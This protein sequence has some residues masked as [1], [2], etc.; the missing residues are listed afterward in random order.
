MDVLTLDLIR[1]ASAPGGD[2]ASRRGR[3]WRERLAAIIAR[4]ER[5]VAGGS[6]GSAVT[7]RRNE[8]LLYTAATIVLGVGLLAVTSLTS[9]PWPTIDP[10]IGS[11]TALAGPTG[12]LLLWLLYGLIGSLRVLRLPGGAAMTFHLPFVGAAMIVGGPTAGAWV[13]FLSTIE[14]RELETQP[15]YG[16]LANHSILVIAAV[17]G[18]IVT[19]L[20]AVAMGP[21]TDGAAL[22]V[23]PVAGA[24]VLAGTSTVLGAV[25]VLLREDLSARALADILLGQVGRITAFECALVVVLAIAYLEVGWWAPLVVAG[26]VLVV[27]DNDPLPPP[28]VVTGLAARETFMRQLDAGVGRLRRRLIP[29]ATILYIDLDWFKL[30]NDN[31]GPETGDETLAEVG[32]RLRAQARRSGDVAGRLGG[33]EFVLFLPGLG[34]HETAVRRADEVVA[35]LC[36]PIGTSSGAM[37]IG[38]S[39]GVVVVDAWGGVPSGATLVAHAASAMHAA[40]AAG[41]GSHLFDP[42]EPEVKLGNRRG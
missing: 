19:K 38:A 32:R 27:W 41:G 23:P 5:M 25:T 11:D 36:L 14:R 40:K 26:F 31:Y 28:D 39:I 3:W 30:I 8:L 29:S 33:D 13:A 20:V 9:T 7:K 17:A 21:A 22:L 15:W 12:G 1:S 2:P 18:G 42:D 37:T 10:G 16:T 6:G 24:L 4:A 35:D 34:D